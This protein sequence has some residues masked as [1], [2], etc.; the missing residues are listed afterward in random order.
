MS[1]LLVSLETPLLGLL[2]LPMVFPF[3]VHIPDVCVS[4]TTL[5]IKTDQVGFGPTLSV[6]THC[7]VTGL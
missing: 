3:W 7:E 4:L 6:E 5:L 1:A 2:S